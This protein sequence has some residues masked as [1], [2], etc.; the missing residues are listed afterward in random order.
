M[1]YLRHKTGSIAIDS[2]KEIPIGVLQLTESSLCGELLSVRNNTPIQLNV[3]GFCR[4]RHKVA[5]KA[6]V[7]VHHSV[8]LLKSKVRMTHAYVSQLRLL[9]RIC[10]SRS[11]LT[12][13]SLERGQCDSSTDPFA[14]SS[15][16]LR[17][18]I[19][20]IDQRSRRLGLHRFQSLNSSYW[21]S[22]NLSDEIARLKPGLF[23]GRPGFNVSHSN[24]N[25]AD[26]SEGASW[27][28]LL[29]KH[30]VLIR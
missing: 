27:R 26:Y 14:R 5:L 16:R 15:I 12:T 17:S 1:S 20:D 8:F 3:N 29:K 21:H 24:Q 9:H 13:V 10:R 23:C 6:A 7:A 4:G 30:L 19:D 18:E 11:P 25:V 22:T 28:L 2:V